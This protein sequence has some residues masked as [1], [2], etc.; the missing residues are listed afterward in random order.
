MSNHPDAINTIAAACTE[1]GMQSWLP[2]WLP[3]ERH[4]ELRELLFDL[5]ISALHAF[6]DVDEFRVPE[7]SIN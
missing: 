2:N 6:R 5:V 7:P 4:E 1:Y 3:A